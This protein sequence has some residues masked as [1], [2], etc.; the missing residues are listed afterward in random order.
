M[1]DEQKSVLIKLAAEM[2]RGE[3]MPHEFVE[4]W[5]LPKT[6]PARARKEIALSSS[7]A[8]WQCREWG[9]RIRKIIDGR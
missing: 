8:H 5:D 6:T 2:V 3:S 7:L 1:T 9:N 4:D